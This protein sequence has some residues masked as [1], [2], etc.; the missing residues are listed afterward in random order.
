MTRFKLPLL[1]SVCALFAWG[2]TAAGPA[3]AWQEEPGRPSPEAA[4]RQALNEDTSLDFVDQPL[5]D[6]VEYLRSQHKIPIQ[7]DEAAL[8]E[9]G[10]GADTPV[11][12]ALSGITLSSALKLMLGQH[13]LTY[14]IDNEVLLITS[15]T[16]AE[17]L[18]ETRVYPVSDLVQPDE[19][20]LVA[21]DPARSFEELIETIKSIIEPTTW[22]EVGGPGSIES[23]A[24]SQA[25][26]V[27]QT[28]DVQEKIV[29]LLAALRKTRDEQAAQ[30]AAQEQPPGGD[31]AM[32]LKV[33]H[34]PDVLAAAF[35]YAPAATPG[36]NAT[37]G[38]EAAPGSPAPG[39]GGSQPPPV[40]P[41]VAGRFAA[42]AH[43]AAMRAVA[44]R[45]LAKV[46]PSLVEPGTWE[47]AGGEGTIHAV[48][49]SL[50]VR[51]TMDVHRQIQRLLSAIE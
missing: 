22:D 44:A 35:A 34:V 11:T 27:S 33:Y 41:Q 51:Q 50:L 37:A 18:L 3:G 42:M 13:D 23:F 20:S 16:E 48:S 14:V 26:V 6:V 38:P 39:A 5:F 25:L 2:L 1:V 43:P 29:D 10:V 30:Q 21:A 19:T 24:N 28:G 31:G 17:G 15:K 36:G 8:T 47:K 12:V 4:I 46:I 7:L 49:G 45:E 40:Q 9:A 32:T